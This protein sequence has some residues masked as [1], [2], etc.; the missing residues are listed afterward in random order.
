MACLTNI[1]LRRRQDKSLLRFGVLG[2]AW[3]KKEW[4][5]RLESIDAVLK[6]SS[7]CD[8][9]SVGHDL[10]YAFILDSV[11]AQT[12]PLS[13]AA[14]AV[15]ELRATQLRNLPVDPAFSDAG[16]ML[17]PKQLPG[18][19]SDEKEFT[20]K[21]LVGDL[22]PVLYTI[23]VAARALSKSAAVTSAAASTSTDSNGMTNDDSENTSDNGNHIAHDIHSRLARQVQALSQRYGLSAD[24][25]AL[26]IDDITPEH[27]LAHLQGVA[28]SSAFLRELGLL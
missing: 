14:S 9:E 15:P 5:Q 21:W 22:R 18:V 16:M 23:P 11:N 27:A 13:A 19:V 28:E 7:W 10:S 20:S 25:D 1:F 17:A 2:S 8:S 4:R 3:T 6:K 12:I 26:K 24:S